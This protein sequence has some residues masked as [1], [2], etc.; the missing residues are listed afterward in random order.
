M[1]QFNP[2][3]QMRNTIN[4]FEIPVTEV[5]RAKKFYSTILDFT[6][7]EDM[8]MM[9]NHMSFFPES[10]DSG[11]VSG[12]LVKS[13][14]HRPSQGGVVI[15]LNANPK[16]IDTILSKVEAAGGQI[17]M[18]NTSL[19]PNGEIAMFADTE[20]NIIGLHQS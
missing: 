7:G 18:P 12:T 6:F 2:L 15:Y 20:G 1:I 4:W 11:A 14:N 17:V 9:G 10:K 8:E 19:G 13:E 5:E 3:T 16:Q